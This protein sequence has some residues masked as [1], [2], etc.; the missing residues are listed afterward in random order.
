MKKYSL[1]LIIFAL[2]KISLAQQ[3][4]GQV[5]LQQTILGKQNGYGVRYQNEKGLGV[6]IVYQSNLNASRE[7]VQGNYP[8][9]GIETVIPITKCNN[10]RLFLTP[11][12]GFVNHLFFV[13][14]PEVET[15]IK[16]SDRFSSGITAGLRARQ[17]AIGIKIIMKIN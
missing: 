13:V 1:L 8:F 5:F 3:L 16:I 11:K 17:S 2:A 10:M 7:F 15:N 9:Y 4:T 6:G 12:V 14:I